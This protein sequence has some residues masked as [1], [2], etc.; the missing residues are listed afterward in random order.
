MQKE[1]EK[2]HVHNAFGGG[3]G[4]G[5]RRDIFTH[6]HCNTNSVRLNFSVLISL[7]LGP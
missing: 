4:G 7:C 2:K 1:E 3:G 6:A 5:G